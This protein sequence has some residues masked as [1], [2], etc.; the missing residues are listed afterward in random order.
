MWKDVS[1][2]AWSLMAFGAVMFLLSLVANWLW[3]HWYVPRSVLSTSEPF[4]MYAFVTL[5]P[6]ALI[7]LGVVMHCISRRL[8]RR[9]AK[10][11]KQDKTGH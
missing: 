6:L 5:G 11:D 7:L 2:V 9:S 1:V 8:Q 10:R 3:P 4:R